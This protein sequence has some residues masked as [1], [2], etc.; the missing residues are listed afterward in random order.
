MIESEAYNTYYMYAT[1][2]KTLRPKYV[3]KKADSKTYPKTKPVQ[4]PKGKRLKA[5]AKV[6]KS[7]KKKLP[8]QGLET[9]SEIALSEAEQMKITTKRSKTQFHVS[10]ASGSG[11]HKGT[12]VYQGFLMYPYMALM[13][14]RSLRSPVMTMKMMMMLITKQ[15][16][17]ISSGF[18]SNMLNPNLD[19]CIDSILNLNTESNSLLANKMNEAVKT[20]VQLQLDILRDE[21]QVENEDF[22]NKL[23][24]N[25]KKIIKEQVKV[26]VQEQVTKILPRIENLFNE[27]LK[28]EVLTRSS[29][30]AKTV[31]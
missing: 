15:S 28:D 29:N 8:A 10:H 2:E 12:C 7:G 21:A 11:V 19:T 13:M 24:E 9:L 27:Q 16:S 31:T 1:G 4:A 23:D 22:I 30:E 3:Q 5:T 6:P 14:I 25:I 20:V 26:Q 17:S 18:I